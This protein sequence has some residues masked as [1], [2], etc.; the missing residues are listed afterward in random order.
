MGFADEVKHEIPVTVAPAV[1]NQEV[2]VN[3]TASVY[4]NPVSDN[5]Y[6]NGEYGLTARALY[7][8][9]A[10]KCNVLLE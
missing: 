9:Q 7:D 8:Y 2:L 10:G 1:E 3:E 4:K 6:L 5:E